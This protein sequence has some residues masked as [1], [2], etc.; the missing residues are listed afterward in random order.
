MR[1]AV[2]RGLSCRGAFFNTEAQRHKECSCEMGG[3]LGIE[4]S[5][6]FFNAETQRRGDAMECS[7]VGQR[8]AGMGGSRG[9]AS[10][11][12]RRSLRSR[13]VPAATISAEIVW[14]A[15]MLGMKTRELGSGAINQQI[16]L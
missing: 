2:R 9:K 10:T 6:G 5:R 13:F 4:M 15:Q 7:C 11:G 1:G 8:H 14:L 16:Y 12:Y 3:A